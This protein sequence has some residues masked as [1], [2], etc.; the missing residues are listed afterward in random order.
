L[1]SSS[2]FEALATAATP[3]TAPTAAIPMITLVLRFIGLPFPVRR[4]PRVDRAG[5]TWGRLETGERA[6]K[7]GL[8]LHRT[9]GARAREFRP[10][11]EAAGPGPPQRAAGSDGEDGWGG[12]APAAVRGRGRERR[13]HARGGTG[14][15]AIRAISGQLAGRWERMPRRCSGCGCRAWQGRPRRGSARH[16]AAAMHSISTRAP[17]ASPLPATV[18][19]AGGSSGK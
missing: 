14:P 5:S 18:D 17:R 4:R 9:Y 1:D 6:P 11:R 8:R 7:P 10:R 19:R 16:P 15:G 13:C 2:P 12:G 3:K